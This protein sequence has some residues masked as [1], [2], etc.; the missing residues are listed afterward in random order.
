MVA[1][2]SFL[3][4]RRPAARRALQE[5]QLGRAAEVPAARWGASSAG[6]S[7]EED[8]TLQ[9][10]VLGAGDGGSVV[11]EALCRQTGRKVAVKAFRREG[12]SA[13]AQEHLTKEMAVSRTLE[14][15][16]LIRVQ[17]VY[18]SEE[19]VYIV[20]E[21]LTGGELFD[22]LEQTGK[23]SEVEAAQ[24]TLQLLQ[25]IVYLHAHD[26]M[27]R[28]IKLENVMY[29]QEGGAHVKLIDLGF[30]TPLARGQQL[31]QRCGSLQYIAPEV[32]ANKGYNEK[33]DLWSLGCVV[34]SLLLAKPVY[35]G[36]KSQ[37]LMKNTTGSIDWVSDFGRLSQSAQDFIG[38]LLSL[39]PDHRPSAKEALSH[40]WMQKHLQKEVGCWS[41]AALGCWERR[42]ELRT[43]ECALAGG[44]QPRPDR[45]DDDASE[46]KPHWGPPVGGG[47]WCSSAPSRCG[48]GRPSRT[49]CK[50]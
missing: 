18:E 26:V 43:S 9:A 27:H 50:S 6:R 37:V 21:Q 39:D 32:L 46:E 35:S 44:A 49:R 12:M 20:M 45:D 41:V 31:W 1:C 4:A 5:R 34:Y 10:R 14:H 2:L 40:P 19:A 22:R 48:A 17:D 23:F 8:Y 38:T 25:A 13:K 36:S 7:F 3:I 29:V 47:P 24:V 11:S 28:D 33:A 30:A 15:P 16:N 42:S